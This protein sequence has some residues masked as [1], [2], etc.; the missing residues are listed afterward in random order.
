MILLDLWMIWSR[1]NLGLLI[2]ILVSGTN[3]SRILAAR[4]LEKMRKYRDSIT[5]VGKKCVLLLMC[6]SALVLW[7][8][9]SCVCL[10]LAVEPSLI[11]AIISRQS[12]AGSKL[13]P[14]GYGQSDPNCFGLMQVCASVCINVCGS[15]GLILCDYCRSIS[16]TT[17]LRETRTAPNTLTRGSPSWSSSLRLWGASGQTGAKS[18]S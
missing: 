6:V 2:T 14:S 15:L 10:R 8:K 16:I 11:A 13:N 3:A 12:E 9:L 1:F 4:D 5:S 7:L 17:L 18:S